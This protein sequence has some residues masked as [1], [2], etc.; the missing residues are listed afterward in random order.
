ML[1]AV[2]VRCVIP[3]HD[4]GLDI[5]LELASSKKKQNKQR[6]Q[7]KKMMIFTIYNNFTFSELKKKIVTLPCNA[8]K[9]YFFNSIPFISINH[10][11]Q[12]QNAMQ[13]NMGRTLSFIYSSL[14]A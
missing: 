9:S 6:N 5:K 4:S 7:K 10:K 14:F 2:D 12:Y 11:K 3:P 13:N 8:D 1:G